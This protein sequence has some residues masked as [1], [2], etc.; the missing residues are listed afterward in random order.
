M[1]LIKLDTSGD[2]TWTVTAGGSGTEYLFG[3]TVTVDGGYVAAGATNSYGHGATDVWL[4][5]YPG[6]SESVVLPMIP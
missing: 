2:T 4:V 3:L 5:R 1:F 6:F